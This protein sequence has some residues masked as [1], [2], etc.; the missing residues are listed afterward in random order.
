MK[1]VYSV[2]SAS[3]TT[4]KKNVDKVELDQD[5]R[6]TCM[7]WHSEEKVNGGCQ[8]WVQAPDTV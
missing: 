6:P 7:H 8:S 2:K 3:N 1:K 4:F 5:H